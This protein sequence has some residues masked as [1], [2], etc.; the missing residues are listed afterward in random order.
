MIS[1]VSTFIQL[2]ARIKSNNPINFKVGV[3]DAKN[4]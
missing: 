4:S 2:N 1:S 3:V